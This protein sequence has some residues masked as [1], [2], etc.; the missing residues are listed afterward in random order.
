MRNQFFLINRDTR[1]SCKLKGCFFLNHVQKILRLKTLKFPL[2]NLLDDSSN[3]QKNLDI[4]KV[5][6]IKH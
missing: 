5:N 2:V 4:S 6:E 1:G 3:S